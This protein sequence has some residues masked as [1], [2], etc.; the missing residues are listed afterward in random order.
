[1]PI[2]AMTAHAMIGD[3]ERCLAA[4]M[5]SYVTKPV[6]ITKLFTAITDAFHKDL[7]SNASQSEGTPPLA[8]AP[9]AIDLDR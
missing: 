8:Q 3:R 1:M 5:D 7:T 6:D 2:V 9:R 4:G